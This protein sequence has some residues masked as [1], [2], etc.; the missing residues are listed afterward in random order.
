MTTPNWKKQHPIRW[1]IGKFAIFAVANLRG[2]YGT[3]NP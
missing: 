3:P 2:L 1:K